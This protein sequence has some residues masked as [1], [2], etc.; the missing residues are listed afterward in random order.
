MH[1][2][3]H[4]NENTY[5]TTQACETIQVKSRAVSHRQSLGNINSVGFSGCGMEVQLEAQEKAPIQSW[6]QVD[7]DKTRSTAL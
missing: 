5:L 2:P 7:N 3:P 6:S 4:I 1:L